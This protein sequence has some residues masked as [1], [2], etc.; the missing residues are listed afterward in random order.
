MTPSAVGRPRPGGLALGLGAQGEEVATGCKAHEPYVWS[1][2]RSAPTVQRWRPAPADRTVRLWDTGRLLRTRYQ[3]HHEAEA[4][5]PQAERLVDA[6]WRQKKD[7]AGVV[8]ALRTVQKLSEPLRQASLLAA[9]RRA[10]LPA[11]AA[12][13]P[14][15]VP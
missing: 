5:R 8:E 15:R 3:A 11:V 13:S 2:G 12:G 10:S 9:L 4:L 7:P 1:L 6:I 14:A